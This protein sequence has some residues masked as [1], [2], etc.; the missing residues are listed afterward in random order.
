MRPLRF[1]S[2]W[3]VLALCWALLATVLWLGCRDTPALRLLDAQPVLWRIQLWRLW[4]AAL[5]HWSGLHL[6]FNLAGC[7]ALMAWGHAADVKLRHTL[8]WLL[9]WPVGQWGL[10]AFSDLPHYGGLSG[11]LH[12]GVAIGCWALLR[13]SQVPR[14]RIGAL[15]LLGVCLKVA[16]EQP[17]LRQALGLD[18]AL[19]PLIGAPGWVVAGGAHLAGLLAGLACAA[20]V[21]GAARLRGW[22]SPGARDGRAAVH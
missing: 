1:L 10:S 19:A 7:A 5:V 17:W 6:V 21:D 20:L 15:V 11:V 14:R 18:E 3:T 2:A 12:A 16:L 9:A 13:Q 8:A 22:F 4:T